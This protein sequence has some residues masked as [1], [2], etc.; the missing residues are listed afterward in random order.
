MSGAMSKCKDIGWSVSYQTSRSLICVAPG[1]T[2]RDNCSS[3][4]TWR[5][6]VWSDGG[7]ERQAGYPTKKGKWYGGHRPCTGEWNHPECPGRWDVK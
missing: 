3:C 6:M 5:L 1:T 4:D 2:Y 7:G